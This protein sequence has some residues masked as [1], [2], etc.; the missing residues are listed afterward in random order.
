[1]PRHKSQKTAFSSKNISVTALLKNEEFRPTASS[2]RSSFMGLTSGK[3]EPDRADRANSTSF[4]TIKSCDATTTDSPT[5][6]AAGAVRSNTRTS[7]SVEM[8]YDDEQADISKDHTDNKSMRTDSQMVTIRKK[9][10][11]SLILEK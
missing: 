1:M 11:I 8:A 5:N 2:T 3:S 9:K 4:Q 10:L 7:T 6:I